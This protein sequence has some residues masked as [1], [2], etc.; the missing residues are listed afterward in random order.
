MVEAH[1]GAVTLPLLPFA[2]L[3]LIR[4]ARST[5]RLRAWSFLAIVLAISAVALVRLHATGGYLAARHALIPGTIL[6]LFAAGG[7]TWL[8]AKISIPGRW[9]GLGQEH[10]KPGPAVWVALGAL[11]LIIPLLRS[12]GPNLPGPFSVYHS[13]GLWLERN[14]RSD[15]AVLDLTDWSLFFSQRPG[16]GSADVFAAPE[17]PKTRWIVLREPDDQHA[18]HYRDVLRELIGDREPVA[19][20]PPDPGPHQ[21]QVRIYDR[22]TPASL[23]ATVTGP[24]GEQTQRR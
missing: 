24:P 6:T 15:D 21:L 3:G 23:A 20:V 14:T 1:C 18:W 8:V 11:L 4:A 22:R 10:V 2:L 19:Q 16:Y 7:M 13:T 9:L 17:D 12:L 5:D